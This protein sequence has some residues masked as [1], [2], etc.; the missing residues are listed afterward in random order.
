MHRVQHCS[1]CTSRARLRTKLTACGA[2]TRI[3][4]RQTGL[5]PVAGSLYPSSS[6]NFFD[7]Y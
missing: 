6:D 2:I 3:F 5:T 1:W 7:S 4:Q